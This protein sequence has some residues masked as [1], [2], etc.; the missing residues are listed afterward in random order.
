LIGGVDKRR[1]KRLVLDILIRAAKGH[2]I[3][4]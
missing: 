2:V 1:K 4:Q 3:G